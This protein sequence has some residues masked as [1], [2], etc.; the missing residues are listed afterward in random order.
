MRMADATNRLNAALVPDAAQ[1][2]ARLIERTGFTKVSVV[3]RA[4]QVYDYIEAELRSGGELVV[5]SP[6]GRMET[7]RI[8]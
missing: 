7:L 5:R 4:L 1:A 2:L 3:N 8:L 6:D